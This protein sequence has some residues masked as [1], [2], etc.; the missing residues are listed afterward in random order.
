[1][2]FKFVKASKIMRVE[3]KVNNLT[4]LKIP[5]W[6][7]S[8]L[9]F[10]R[11]RLKLGRSAIQIFNI[12]MTKVFIRLKKIIIVLWKINIIASSYVICKRDSR[13]CHSKRLLRGFAI[14][15]KDSRTRIDVNGQ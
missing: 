5:T 6:E 13:L 10:T 4:S 9:Q 3:R 1:M 8:D 14:K 11:L 12:Y 7:E 2:N 15:M